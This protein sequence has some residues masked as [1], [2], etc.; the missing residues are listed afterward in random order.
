MQTCLTLRS[1][2]RR[3]S[4]YTISQPFA[5][6]IPQDIHSSHQAL[7]K[8][9]DFVLCVNKIINFFPPVSEDLR[10]PLANMS[11]EEQIELVPLHLSYL[12]WGLP[13]KTHIHSRYQVLKYKYYYHPDILKN[14]KQK[15]P[16]TAY[17]CCPPR[18]QS[19]PPVM[20]N[21]LLSHLEI[22]SHI[23]VFVQ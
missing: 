4:S 13:Q 9:S 16:L 14:Y 20:P 21:Y 22:I 10:N 7:D 12:K 23:L 17:S 5:T 15:A 3:L 18:H 1:N 6:H 19:A 11:R 2:P 8:H